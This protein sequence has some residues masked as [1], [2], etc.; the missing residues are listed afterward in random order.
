M[1]KLA[2]AAIGAAALLAAGL[3]AGPARADKASNILVVG[4]SDDP[5]SLD[6]ATGTLGSEMPFNYA[7]YDR[8]IDLVPN[9]LELRPQLATAWTWSADKLTLELDLRGGVKFQDGTDF[10]AAAVKTSL[11]HFQAVK[12]SHDLD[13]VTGIEVRDPHTVLIHVAAPYS[14]LP[15]ILADRAGMIVSPAAL[16]KGP[17]ELRRHPVGAGP[18]MLTDWTVGKAVSMRRFDGYW[19][20]AAIKLSGI[21][22]KIIANPT[23]LVA[24]LQ[25][26]QLDY[27]AGL[28]T[29]NL[30]V[31]RKNKKLVTKIEPTVAWAMLELD[32]GLAPVDDKRVRQALNYAVD[33]P[34][35]A[36]A[37]YGPG[38]G[39]TGATLPYP[40]SF[41]T[42]T[43]S[44][45]GAYTYDPAKARALLAAAGHPDGITL[46]LC[47]PSAGALIPGKMITD[48][49]QQQMK[50]AGITV[51][52]QNP[53]TTSA[54]VQ[55][56]NVQKSIPSM[57]ISWTGRPDP[58]MTYSQMF[59]T[60]GYYNAAHTTYPGVDET[61]D[62]ILAASGE[63]Q[64][65][66][67]YDKLNAAW[68]DGAPVVPLFYWVYVVSYSAD[69]GGEEPSLLARSNVRSLYFK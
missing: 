8:L 23:S 26:G 5:T 30:P 48:I 62:Q 24:A 20:K 22:F 54:C 44:L 33:R 56:F 57:V 58:W 19:N 38:V 45:A 10:D 18:F 12:I 53:P 34:A 27:G 51:V 21:D 69:L 25:D 29:V 36:T 43:K 50:P 28:D 37:V 60:K 6:P 67:L 2:M 41:W 7:I 9:T 63:D 17:D 11:E 61:L 31:L 55:L 68:V 4:W 52:P 66:P 47:G 49:L 14:V 35:L 64:Q 16:A 46:N 32:T 65:K 59:G 15:A 39:A 42:T 40:P 3:P 13:P 1:R